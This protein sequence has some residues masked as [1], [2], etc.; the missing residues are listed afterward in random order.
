VAKPTSAFFKGQCPSGSRTGAVDQGRTATET[1]FS[2]LNHKADA[3]AQSI[4]DLIAGNRGKEAMCRVLEVSASGQISVV[5]T[6][7]STR[8][9]AKRI[10]AQLSAIHQQSRGTYGGAPNF[11]A[12]SRQCRP[13]RVVLVRTL[14]TVLPRDR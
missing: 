7:A 8:A 12:S 5:Q 11:V 6:L 10:T 13:R 1:T 14:R 3:L 2:S 9:Q 4:I